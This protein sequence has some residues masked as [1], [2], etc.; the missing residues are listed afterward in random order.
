MPTARLK[1]LHPVLAALPTLAVVVGV[2]LRGPD[3]FSDLEAVVRWAIHGVAAESDRLFGQLV[4]PDTGVFIGGALAGA[5]A[6]AFLQV[7]GW[8]RAEGLRVT[9]T[10]PQARAL[11]DACDRVTRAHCPR[12]RGPPLT[13]EAGASAGSPPAA[14]ETLGSARRTLQEARDSAL[15]GDP[16]R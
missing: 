8:G 10:G 11:T 6:L 9:L 14:L 4:P 5:A 12:W 16:G 1:R 7:S 2:V 3:L 13:P 15:N